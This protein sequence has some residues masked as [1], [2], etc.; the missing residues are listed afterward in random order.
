MNTPKLQHTRDGRTLCTA[1]A[2]SGAPSYHSEG[3]EACSEARAKGII[4]P[5]ITT[6]PKKKRGRAYLQ[7]KWIDWARVPKE[8]RADL[9][10]CVQVRRR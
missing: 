6:V 1:H 4:R 7:E 8:N 10:A 5:D 3:C 2:T 9:A